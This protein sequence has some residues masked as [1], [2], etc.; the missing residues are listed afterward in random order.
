NRKAVDQWIE[1]QKKNQ[2]GAKTA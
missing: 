2:P 1:A